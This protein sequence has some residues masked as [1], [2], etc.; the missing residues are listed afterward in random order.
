MENTKIIANGEVIVSASLMCADMGY[1]ADDLKKIENSG[2]Q[3]LH[4]DVMDAHF[5]PNMPAGLAMLDATT[6]HSR[7]PLD[8][9]LMVENNDFFIER[10]APY[11]CDYVS[12]HAESARHLDRT[13]Q[14]IKS[15]GAKA[16]VALNPATPP[17]V[18]DYVLHL[19]DFVLVMTVN[20]GYAGQNLVGSAW[21]KI[22]DVHDYLLSKGSN[23]AIEV[24][25]NVSFENIPRMVAAGADILVAGTSSVFSK[26]AS[27][28][29]N[30]KRVNELIAQG[31]KARKLTST[32]E[33]I[34]AGTEKLATMRRSAE[35]SSL[36][37]NK[38]E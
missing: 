36:L 2:C 25:G 16:G 26:V 27:R 38:T 33:V 23:A 1:Y 7:L 10:I 6:K 21:Q 18:L 3:W 28:A 8:V 37:A 35:T 32:V 5:V 19:T 15:T 14:L 34:K 13:L 30:M 22:S 31:I 29:D 4:F 24:D 12:V 9:H 20:P 11:K 17:Q